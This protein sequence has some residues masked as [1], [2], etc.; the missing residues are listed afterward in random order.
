MGTFSSHVVSPVPAYPQT[1]NM[2]DIIYLERER[3]AMLQSVSH[4]I[5][6]ENARKQ[7]LEREKRKKVQE[8][9]DLVNRIINILR[10]K[11]RELIIHVNHEFE[12]VTQ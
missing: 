8:V 7:E 3:A 5:D 2:V 4:L 10:L 1:K 6:K 11:E 12:Q 9:K